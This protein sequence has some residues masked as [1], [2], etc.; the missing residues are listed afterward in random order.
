MN[1]LD[2]VVGVFG[3][4]DTYHVLPGGKNVECVLTV[5][6][7]SKSD[8][9]EAGGDGQADALKTAYSDALKRAA[10]KFGIGRHLYE[11]EMQWKLFDGY[12]IIEVAEVK[13]KPEPDSP[14]PTNGNG[15]P[16]MS[17]PK[18]RE[19]IMGNVEGFKDDQ[20]VM[21]TIKL[22]GYKQT[23]SDPEERRKLV[24]ALTAYRAARA[25]GLN[26]DDALAQLGIETAK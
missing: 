6:G 13:P 7:V 17:A 10:V 8:V 4:S 23:P 24:S 25:S 18:F 26:K 12:K 14:V 1:R 16:L 5:L 20:H 2:D 22:L 11:M 21:A 3:W 9:G 19:W 15:K